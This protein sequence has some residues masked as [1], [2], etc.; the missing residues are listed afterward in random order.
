MKRENRSRTFSVFGLAAMALFLLGSPGARAQAS[1]YLGSITAIDGN[2]LTVKTDAGESHQV[3]VPPD[4]ILKRIA[5][6]ERDLTKAEPLDFAS[7]AVNDRVLVTLDPKATDALPHALR[8]IAIKKADVEQK[9]AAESNAWSEGVH[10]LVKTIDPSTGVIVVSVRAGTATK[11]VTVN[12]TAATVLKRYAP[13]S[14]RFDQAV[15]APIAAIAPGDQFWARGTKNADGSAIAADGVV[16]GSF[17]SIPGTVIS[18]DASASTL[19]VKD[20]ASKKSVTVRITSD[21]QLR[22]L[23]DKV[24][25]FLAARLKG[26]AAG[27]G[28]SGANG[29]S[30]GQRSSSDAGAGNGGQRAWGQG[31]AGG[32]H[33]DFE[34]IL[35]HAPA[36]Q[37]G[38]LKKGDA[39]MIVATEDA[40]GLSAVKLLAGVEPLLEAPEAQ[41]LLSSWS[42]SNGESEAAQ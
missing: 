39:V 31:R 26:S 1:R 29:G 12:T 34:T 2:T 15:T 40:S 16:S 32:G 38:E 24:A 33:M 5:P 42:L 14:I 10:G 27:G 35:E 13:G 20:L 6:G 7:L 4:A 18:A 22:R 37:L 11:E 30:S 41:N 25:A 23:D 17:R 21:A 3:Q 36:I 9:Q 8:I 19:T 28:G